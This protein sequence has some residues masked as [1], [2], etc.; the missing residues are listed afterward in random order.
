MT[1]T[2]SN[3]LCKDLSRQRRLKLL[4]EALGRTK[5]LYC[6]VAKKYSIL[7][8]RR[9]IF[10]RALILYSFF[11]QKLNSHFTSFQSMPLADHMA[12][13]SKDDFNE[14]FHE[15]RS[16]YSRSTLPGERSKLTACLSGRNLHIF[17]GRTKN[18]EIVR[19]LWQYN[20]ETQVW[21]QYKPSELP[22]F[23]G[24]AMACT[25]R[26][27]SILLF[28]FVFDFLHNFREK[29]TSLVA[30]I[31]DSDVHCGS[32]VQ[33]VDWNFLKSLFKP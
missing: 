1:Q 3:L 5:P 31:L 30:L 33:V 6:T 26:V 22:R 7:I 29:S 15:N 2:R 21:Y 27:G 32:G 20:I 25:E 4:Y 23:E 14:S 18:G 19:D 9:I 10:N 12:L 17:G 28:L 11:A 8:N 16:R 24:H 13:W